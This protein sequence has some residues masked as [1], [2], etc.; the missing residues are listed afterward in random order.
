MKSHLFNATLVL[1]RYFMQKIKTSKQCGHCNKLFTSRKR[2]KERNRFCS[3]ECSVDYRYGEVITDGEFYARSEAGL[4]ALRLCRNGLAAKEAAARAGITARVLSNEVLRNKGIFDNR[5]CIECGKSLVGMSR[6]EARKYCSGA[7]S[8]RYWQKLHP[9]HAQI[10]QREKRLSVRKDFIENVLALHQNGY[11]VNE[12]AD[13]LEVSISRVT[14]CVSRHRSHSEGLFRKERQ[15]A[16]S[17]DQ[18]VA[19]LREYAQKSGYKGLYKKNTKKSHILCCKPMSGNVG[20]NQLITVIND[21]LGHNPHNGDTYVFRNCFGGTL[22]AITWDEITFSIIKYS[23][24]DYT[25]IWPHEGLGLFVA[26]SESE[27]K[28][29][30]SYY[31]NNQASRRKY[32]ENIQKNS[33]SVEVVQGGVMQKA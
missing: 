7:C 14:D 29:I 30:L 17:P 10:A 16:N 4:L 22:T 12:I 1:G 6:I 21:Y 27:F 11:S 20:N 2:G 9:N 3:R 24:N 32:F 8:T 31:K 13:R 19:V 28:F 26:V 33:S 18:W 5:A 25:Y 15:L 23:R